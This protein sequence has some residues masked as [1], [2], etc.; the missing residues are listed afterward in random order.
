V[1]TARNH[2]SVSRLN[3]VRYGQ[4]GRRLGRKVRR[5][6]MPP[7]EHIKPRMTRPIAMSIVKRKLTTQRLAKKRK[8]G[9]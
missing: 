3:G 4:S 1:G 9:M 6:Q 8:T 7:K 5:T 2:L